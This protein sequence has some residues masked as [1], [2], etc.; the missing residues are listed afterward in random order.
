MGWSFPHLAANPLKTHETRRLAPNPLKAL[1][2]RRIRA[3]GQGEA[4][5]ARSSAAAASETT[6]LTALWVQFVVMR[7]ILYRGY[8]PDSSARRH[9]PGEHGHAA[10]LSLRLPPKKKAA[11]GDLASSGFA[12]RAKTARAPVWPFDSPQSRAPQTRAASLPKSQAQ[13][14]RCLRRR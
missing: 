13:G 7:S 10:L 6:P 3:A 9:R 1:A 8:P 2:R 12:F 14:W 4:A 11:Q 5:P